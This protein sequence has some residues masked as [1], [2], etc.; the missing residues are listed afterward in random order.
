[1]SLSIECLFSDRENSPV[2]IALLCV[3][4]S[5]G[6]QLD[7]CVW[8]GSFTKQYFEINIV[9]FRECSIVWWDAMVW[10]WICSNSNKDVSIC[11]CVFSALY[12][13][14]SLPFTNLFS[15]GSILLIIR[16]SCRNSLAKNIASSHVGE[17]FNVRMSNIALEV[18]DEV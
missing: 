4:L 16:A 3:N 7:L 5:L 10:K 8:S 14:L 9:F 6:C 1:M 17:W 18:S 12:G 13:E 15:C 2:D 11:S